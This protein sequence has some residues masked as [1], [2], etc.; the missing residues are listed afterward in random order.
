MQDKTIAVL[1][2]RQEPCDADAQERKLL[3][4]IA[5]VRVSG[6]ALLKLRHSAREGSVLRRRLRG[7]RKK[8]LIGFYIPGEELARPSSQTAYLG[9]MY[10]EAMKDPELGAEGD[11][12]LTLICLK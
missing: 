5:T 10:P 3:F 6:N 7:L 1:D 12:T 8:N 9:V 2:L 11:E 4:A